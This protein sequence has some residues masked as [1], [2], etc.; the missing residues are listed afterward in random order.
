ML[1]LQ[2]CELLF[3]YFFN[4]N[5][6]QARGSRSPLVDSIAVQS[7]VPMTPQKASCVIECSPPKKIRL[8]KLFNFFGV[9]VVLKVVFPVIY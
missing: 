6:T 5:H 1:T 9:F 2:A 8:R 7:G 4:Y 3:Y